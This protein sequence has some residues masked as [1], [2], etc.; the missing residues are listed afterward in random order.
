[1]DAPFPTPALEALAAELSAAPGP[2]ERSRLLLG[3]A[4][5]LPAYPEAARTDAH[6]VMGCT[7]QVRLQPG[8]VAWP[9]GAGGPCVGRNLARRGAGAGRRWLKLAL[10]P[11]ACSLTHP[12]TLAAAPGR[13]HAQVWVSA[14]LDADGRV[15][16]A[17]DSDAE[18]SRGLAA[19][20]V[21]GLSG[22]TPAEV[23]AVD[24]G[25]LARLGLGP[26]VL[27]RSRA[28]GFLNMLE[29]VKKR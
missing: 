15:R 10:V 28:N 27:T 24:P 8:T 13:S 18:L 17:A 25:C 3:Y 4:R 11:L 1:M 29:A 19:V 9:L 23:A 12:A 7:A 26:A 5:R 22:L 21:E 16:L 14:E 2:Q 6:R 20:L